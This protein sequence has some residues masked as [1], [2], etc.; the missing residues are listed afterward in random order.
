MWK[1]GVLYNNACLI[2][3]AFQVEDNMSSETWQ[4]N[5]NSFYA[6]PPP[7]GR[8][9]NAWLQIWDPAQMTVS[10]K[11]LV[12]AIMIVALLAFEIFNFDTTRYALQSFLGEVTFLGIT[13]AAILAVAFCAID[14]AGLVRIFTPQRG[15]DEPKET[16]YLMGA[17]FLGATMNAVMTWWAVSLTLLNHEFG[18]EVLGREQLLKIVPVFVALL[19]WLTR[20]MFIGALGVAGEQLLDAHRNS[21]R[22]PEAAPELPGR[23]LTRPA[24]T[25]PVP[26]MTAPARHSARIREREPLMTATPPSTTSAGATPKRR[27]EAEPTMV[28]PQIDV[29]E[30]PKRDHP[31]VRQRPPRTNGPVRPTMLG[32][33]PRQQA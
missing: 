14:F 29:D 21:G 4:P 32:Q 24:V 8:R 28:A 27:I 16:W 10:R 19:V 15:V 25:Q 13:W 26:A 22:Q 33:G 5:Q 23:S 20:I 12:G 18:N 2:R 30:L 17:W 9:L 7:L 11:L 3:P 6:D 31:R 1:D